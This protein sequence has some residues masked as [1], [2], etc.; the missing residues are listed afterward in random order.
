VSGPRR[1]DTI[2]S[3]SRS[4]GTP[5]SHQS[6]L[7]VGVSDAVGGCAVRLLES[8]GHRVS[9]VVVDHRGL[10]GLGPTTRV[11]AISDTS[12]LRREVRSHDVVAFLE[13]L[14]ADPHS[15][16]A[17][18]WRTP[19]RARQARDLSVLDGALEAETKPGSRLILRSTTA[20]YAGHG[21]AWIDEEG[22][23]EPSDGTRLAAWAERLA[24]D[25]GRRGGASV[26]LR[27]A[28]PYG[29][30]D[31]WT[32]ESFRLA[33]KGWQP[34]A[35][36]DDAYVPLVG[37]GDAASAIT[38]ALDAPAGVYNVADRYPATNS[39]L[40][41]TLAAAVG[42][43]RLHPLWPSI[44][45]ADRDRLTRSLRVDSDRFANATGWHS[46]VAPNIAGITLDIAGEEVMS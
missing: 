30:G 13:P 23:I 44:R 43:P 26:V 6:V 22:D 14:V 10:R 5:G 45:R 15:A 41:A 32:T 39:Q 21:H 24:T 33:A 7:A 1:D 11:V 38:H 19:R 35:G 28:R 9:A 27:M 42:Q 29:R 17:H 34:F 31:P 4:T 16:T 46:T 8:T 20:L 18:L 40:N 2:S 12:Q 3:S 36:P 25:H 37:A